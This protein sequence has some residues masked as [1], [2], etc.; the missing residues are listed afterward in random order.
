[1]YSALVG[2]YENLQEQP[3]ALESSIPFILFTDDPELRSSTWDVHLIE[4][5][6]AGDAIR[7]ARSLKIRGN[8]LIDSYDESLWID[9]RVR[10][11]VDPSVVLDSWLG[12]ADVA[13]FEHSFRDRLIDEFSAVVEGGYDDPA[14]VYEQFTYYAEERP[15]LLDSKPLWTGMIARRKTPAV[16]LAMSQWWTEVEERSRRD[17]LSAPILYSALDSSLAVLPSASN[18]QSGFHEWPPITAALG[19][20]HVPV[21]DRSATKPP[22]LRLREAEVAQTTLRLRV[23][24]FE[25]EELEW[26]RKLRHRDEAVKHLQGAVDALREDN[27]RQDHVAREAITRLQSQL[28]TAVGQ[29]AVLQTTHKDVSQGFAN[30]LG[31]LK[32]EER[33]GIALREKIARL[34]RKLH[35]ARE[36]NERL[37]AEQEGSAKNLASMQATTAW[38]LARFLSGPTRLRALARKSGTLPIRD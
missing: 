36:E 19:R 12:E 15:E 14:R 13:I 34:R 2:R 23:A 31:L 21:S 11:R 22:L 32:N 29:L 17:Q 16:V 27:E 6:V 10:L 38:K 4:P 26:Q 37:Q 5:S 7:S 25:A 30:A 28:S 18:E 1:V 24:G 9:N 33:R 20:R 3:I 8:G 35:T